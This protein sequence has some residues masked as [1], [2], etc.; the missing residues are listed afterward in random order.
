MIVEFSTV[1]LG[2]TCSTEASI[3]AKWGPKMA[4]KLMLRLHDLEAAE[5]LEDMRTLPGRC[6]ELT[7][8][9]KGELAMYLVHPRR[10]VF[11]P[12]NEPVP[13]KPDGGLDWKQVTSISVTDIR[14][15]H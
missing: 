9:R 12:N 15:Y 13:T 10:L 11:K 1:K 3:K 14:D 8:N 2:K 4:K 7:N 6:H 5:T